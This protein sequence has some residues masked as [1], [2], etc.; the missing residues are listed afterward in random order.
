MSAASARASS[1]FKHRAKLELE[2]ELRAELP[3][4]L[5]DA[6]DASLLVGD[7]QASPDIDRGQI[8]HLAVGADRDLRRAA[9]DVDIHHRRCV[10][11]GAR[12]RARAVGRHHGFQIVARAHRDQLAGLAREQFADRARVAAA[13]GDAG[14]D[15]RPGVDLLGLHLRVL[16]L[17]ADERAERVRVDGFVRRVGRQQDVGFVE[18]L[19]QRN[20]VAAVQP[21]Q[22][23]PREHQMRGRRADIHA[24]RQDADLV[25][26]LE[27]A[28]LAGEEN[29][30]AFRFIHTECAS[31]LSCY[32]RR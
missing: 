4:G 9:A 10:A 3:S 31:C 22:H 2:A 30:A 16:I 5:F 12:D 19:A 14:Q 15:Q 7:N 17:L 21:L 13:H 23:D 26:T 18:C 20:D 8:D 25:F 24:H 29:P 32:R 1:G 28:S 27:R 11:D 6:R